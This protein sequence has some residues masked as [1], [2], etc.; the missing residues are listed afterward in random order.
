MANEKYSY[1]NIP[2]S[3]LQ[4]DHRLKECDQELTGFISQ[5][6]DWQFNNELAAFPVQHGIRYLDALCSVKFD[7]L[8]RNDRQKI[9]EVMQMILKMTNELLPEAAMGIEKEGI[10]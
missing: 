5:T 10:K 9:F 7:I 4:H 6:L 3:E 2:A 1:E 8:G